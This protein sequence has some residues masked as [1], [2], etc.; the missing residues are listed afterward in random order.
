M[1]I[2]MEFTKIMMVEEQHTAMHVGSG[3]VEVLATPIMVSLMEGASAQ[4]VQPYLEDGTTTVGTMIQ[5]THLSATPIGM[6]VTATATIVAIQGKK[7]EFSILARDSSGLIGEAIHTRVI[8]SLEKF[9]T[10]AQEKRVK[11]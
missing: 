9:H 6:E 3:I 4:G 11:L 7:I 10:K 2:G 1:K 5:T 8:V